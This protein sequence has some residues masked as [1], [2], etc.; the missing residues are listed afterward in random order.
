VNK[1]NN[2][3]FKVNTDLVNYLQSEGSFILDF[4]KTKNYDSYLNNII[5]FDIAKTYINTPFYLNVNID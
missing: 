4:L 3:K 5:S 1:L 2:L